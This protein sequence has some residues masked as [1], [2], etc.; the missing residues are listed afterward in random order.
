MKLRLIEGENEREI[1]TAKTQEETLIE[2]VHNMKYYLKGGW[3]L[4]VKEDDYY[5]H[6]YV[7][8]PHG[9]R[10]IVIKPEKISIFWM[11]QIFWMLAKEHPADIIKHT[12]YNKQHNFKEGLRIIEN[13]QKNH[14][15]PSSEIAGMITDWENLCEELHHGRPKVENY[16][17]YFTD[18]R[19]GLKKEKFQQRNG[20]WLFWRYWYSTTQEDS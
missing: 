7:V 11:Q 1:D 18:R 9:D 2:V 4:T 15:Q 19:L 5:K 13:I 14:E 20:Y 16:I 10:W 17:Y 3:E 12:R 6:V 8:E